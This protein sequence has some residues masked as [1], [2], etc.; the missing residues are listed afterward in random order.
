MRNSM[1]GLLLVLILVVLPALLVDGCGGGGGG[2]VASGGIGGTGI[3]NGTVT[4]FGSVFVNGVEYDTSGS[5]FDVDDDSAATENDLGLGMVVTVTGRINN[6]GVTGSAQ[7]IVYDDSLDGPIAGAPL[8]DADLVTKTFTVF[9]TTVVVNRNTTV[10]VNAD[11]SGLAQDDLVEISGFYAAGA[12]LQA[13]RLEGEG[14]LVLG[15]SEVELRGTVSGCPPGGCTGSLMLGSVTVTYDGTTDLSQVPGGMIA[16]GDYIEVSG[17]L[18]TATSISAT[19]IEAESEGF[20]AEVGMISIEGIVTDFNGIGDF[21]VAAQA[22]DASGAVFDPV[23][24]ATAIADGSW[25]EVEGSITG[26]TLQAVEVEQRGGLVEAGAVVVGTNVAAG[27]ISLQ[28]VAG[29]PDLAISTNTRTELEDDRDSVEPFGIADIV[30]GDYLRVQAFVDDQGAVIADRIVR[31]AMDNIE[32]QGPVDVPPTG[33][34]SAAGTVS[35]FGI[36]ITTDAGT[37]FEDAGDTSITG[38]MFYGQVTDGDLVDF[39]DE[40]PADG[41]A[42]GVEFEN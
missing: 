34:T 7:S 9:D 20:G 38:T 4:G 6:D 30:P 32:L 41:I 37:E 40:L 29:Q 36:S 35:I 19:R 2:D 39:E 26:G 11:Y 42:E 24:L 21:R 27:T 1:Q 14:T 13:T 25:V 23:L 33:G 10:F 5:S 18:E 8:E 17:V 31:R 12:V 3:S 28:V 15:V 16:N 22:V